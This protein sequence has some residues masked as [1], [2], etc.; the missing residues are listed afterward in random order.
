MIS[1]AV[2]VSRRPTWKSRSGR[3]ATTSD[4]VRRPSGPDSAET[5][6]RGLLQGGEQLGGGGERW[7]GAGAPP[8]PPPR[9]RA[10]AAAPWAPSRPEAPA[11]PPPPPETDSPVP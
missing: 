5:T 9:A 6:P 1:P 4:S 11:P 10:G 2:S 3:S 7:G 8:P